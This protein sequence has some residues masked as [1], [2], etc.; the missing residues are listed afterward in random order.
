MQMSVERDAERLENRGVN[1]GGTRRQIARF[2]AQAIGAAINLPAAN[3]AAGKENRIGVWIMI[4]PC[5]AI[6]TRRAAEIGEQHDKRFIEPATL[7]EFLY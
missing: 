5:T 1:V 4:A 6:D 3:A 7:I 2:G